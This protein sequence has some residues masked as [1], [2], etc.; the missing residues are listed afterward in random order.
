[1]HGVTFFVDEL[2]WLMTW[3]WYQ[4][5][6][7]VVFTWFMFVLMGRM[8]LLSAL[9]LTIGSYAFAIFIYFIFVTCILINFFQW[10]F[11]AGGQPDVYSAFNAS[12][13][14]ACILS[15]FQCLSYC[16]IKYNRPFD[17]IYFFALSLISNIL[18]ALC[19]SFFIKLT[20]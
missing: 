14:L 16:L 3:G 19:S 15:V 10:K 5:A 2:L 7:G 8:K 20:F 11:L 18:A 13:I 6:L 9:L 4:L 17:V 1:M 12:L